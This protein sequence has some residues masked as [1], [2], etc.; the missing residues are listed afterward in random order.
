MEQLKKKIY[1]AVLVDGKAYFNCL[2][3]LLLQ[4]L[5]ETII[6][7]HQ[8]SA[9]FVSVKYFNFTSLIGNV[10]AVLSCMNLWCATDDKG[11]HSLNFGLSL[12]KTAE[13]VA[14]YELLLFSS[15][16]FSPDIQRSNYCVPH[17]LRSYR[18]R[19]IASK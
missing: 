5:V 14:I 16:I 17:F 8:D 1:S 4:I 18:G 13:F 19:F 3:R 9:G 6:T 11:D 15:L 7:L 2:A 10:D 12:S